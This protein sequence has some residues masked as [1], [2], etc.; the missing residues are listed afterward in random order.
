[1]DWVKLNKAGYS[2]Q[3]MNISVLPYIDQYL[4]RP[5]A[6][7]PELDLIKN[8]FNQKGQ[9]F[10]LARVGKCKKKYNLPLSLRK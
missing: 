3:P 7:V 2:Y 10:W 1:M 6:V 5:N 9:V 4:S 8:E